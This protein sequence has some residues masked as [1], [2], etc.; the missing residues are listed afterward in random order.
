[1]RAYPPKLRAQVLLGDRPDWWRYDR[2]D[3]GPEE[4]GDPAY[5][6]PDVDLIEVYGQV[7]EVRR[8][9][10]PLV[11]PK[12]FKVLKI[13]PEVRLGVALAWAGAA[14]CADIVCLRAGDVRNVDDGFAVNWVVTKS[15]PFRLGR[16]TGVVLVDKWREMQQQRLKVLVPEDQLFPDLSWRLMDGAMK[17]LGRGLSGH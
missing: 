12:S 6:A 4:E 2:D 7:I 13:R 9:S 16:T 5:G 11:G 8:V 17:T 1:M 10:R 3:Y 15:D 14:R